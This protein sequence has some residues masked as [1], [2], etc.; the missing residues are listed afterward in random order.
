MQF[1]PSHE[2]KILLTPEQEKLLSPKE[3]IKEYINADGSLAFDIFHEEKLIGF[4]LLRKFDDGCY[5]LWDYAI[6]CRY[7][8]R[9][10]GSAALKELI[11][12]LK[13]NMDINTLTTTYVWG[14]EHA[15]SLYENTG[16]VETDV[17]DE[18]GIHEVNMIYHIE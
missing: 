10:Y 4:V 17:V 11:E 15:K 9:H 7:Q 6:D 16:F 1:V 8:N 14:N 3:A 13:E 5:F 18:N 2:M 12:F